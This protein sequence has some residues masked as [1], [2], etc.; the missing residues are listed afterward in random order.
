[1]TEAAAQ[2]YQHLNR[3]TALL[4]VFLLLGSCEA[5]QPEEEEVAARVY[6]RYLYVSEV[7]GVIPENTPTPDSAVLAQNYIQKWVE[8]NLLLEKAELNLSEEKK[9]VERQLN[10]Y[11]NSLIIY[12]YEK[13]LV[14][15]KL[16]TNVS[17]EE[18]ETYYTQNK[19]NFELRD[20][21][22]RVRYLKLKA[23]SPNLKK[24]RGWML[25]DKEED[26][27]GLQ[28]YGHQF[29]VNFFND[30]NKWLYFDELLK[31]IPLNQYDK[32][33]FL[34]TNKSRLFELNTTEYVFLLVVKD[35]RLKDSISPLAL[36]KENIRKLILNNR[37][38]KLI[39]DVKKG[40]YND[41]IAKKDIEVY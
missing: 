6:E 31:E 11:R 3:A 30:D 21:I 9:N 32:E 15:Q 39:N 38:L 16:D 34:R 27:L 20:Y 4:P 13:E 28:D 1:L 35:Y 5:F 33:Q 36:E 24:V 41:A 12:A 29:A 22:V 2:N 10:D 23:N 8:Q 37:K 14:R 19:E 25:S 17:D 18:I 40:L 7:A 26:Q